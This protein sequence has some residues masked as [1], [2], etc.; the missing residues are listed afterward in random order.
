M[1]QNTYE[2]FDMGVSMM[3]LKKGEVSMPVHKNGG[4]GV[5]PCTQKWCGDTLAAE[6]SAILGT[7]PRCVSMTKPYCLNNTL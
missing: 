3:E 2:F 5:D 7:P 1:S 6:D 4:R